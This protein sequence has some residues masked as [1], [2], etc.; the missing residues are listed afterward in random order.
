MFKVKWSHKIHIK[1]FLEDLVKKS[2][3]LVLVFKKDWLIGWCLTPTSAVFQ[4]YHGM[5][6]RK[7][8]GQMLRAIYI[9]I[10]LF[11]LNELNKNYFV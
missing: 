9:V 5:F 6:L 11:M 4:L 2:W 7:L 3:G 1:S 10:L 8:H